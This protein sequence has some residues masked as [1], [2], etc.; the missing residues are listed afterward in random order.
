MTIL[1]QMEQTVIIGGDEGQ[2]MSYDIETHELIDVW[3][4]GSKI[5]AI[6]TLSLEEGGFIIAAGTYNGNV[7][8]RQD[9][10][11]IIPRNHTCGTKSINDLSFSK[12]AQLL[13]A[14]STDRHIYL[15]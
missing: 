10:E 14:A 11:E 1:N 13:A 7:I 2:I 3:T 15:F 8:I 5:T 4:V 9:W 12:N 6:S